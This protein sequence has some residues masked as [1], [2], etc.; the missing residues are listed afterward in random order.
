[1]LSPR[2]ARRRGIVPDVVLAWGRKPS[3][4]RAEAYA[5]ANGLPLWR[6]EDGWIR[7]AAR[8]AHSPACYSLLVDPEGVYYD[9]GAPSALESF[10][11]R[12][13]AALR[14]DVDERALERAA[15]A[16]LRLVGADITKYNYCRRAV[17][18]PEDGRAL[19]L[20]V[21]QT[22]D[23]ASVRFGG[24]DEARFAAML[25]A[26]IAENPDARVL[27]RTHPDVVA[28]RRRGYLDAVARER[29]VALAAAG[30][31]PL[32][33]LKRAARVYVGTSQ[34]GYEALLC[35]CAVTVFGE[36]FYAGWGLTDDRRVIPRRAHR[37]SLDELFHAAHIHLARYVSPIS[38]ERWEIED[39]LE[40]VALQRETLARNARHFLCFGIRPWKRRYL[41]QFLRSPDGSVRFADTPGTGQADTLLAWGFR[42]E[43]ETVARSGL[44]LWRVEDG[45][46]RSA[47]LG[48]NFVAPGSFVVDTRGLYFDPTGPSDL[49]VML[50]SR[51]CTL[52]EVRRAASLRR[53]I[54]DAGL[55]KYNIGTAGTNSPAPADR[56]KVL[57]VG[58]V[59]DDESIRRGCDG[60][61]SDTAL[62]QAVRKARP[63]AWIVY[64]PHPDVL[65]GNRSGMA[66][67]LAVQSCADRVDTEST[68]G[69]C[70]DACDELHT[71][72]SLAGFEALMRGR[73]V[74]TW[75]APFYA[76]W[77]LTED[78]LTVPRRTRR[79]TLDELVFLTLVAYP[80]YVDIASGEFV[81]AE[82]MVRIIEGQ[83]SRAAS[84]AARRT[85]WI[86]RRLQ[87]T[88]NIVRGLRYAP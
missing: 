59:G 7:S 84:A 17:L 55:S 57:V 64:R 79:R 87:R 47:G 70:I 44:P 85:G 76:G 19:V 73:N 29:G 61:D 20:V 37:R 35:G 68:I 11:N 81:T 52:A 23:D 36:P 75:G 56:G 72:T 6:L 15:R 30:D 33:W 66:D 2:A 18:P 42:E 31:D 49:E 27:V 82:D 28:G 69:D 53:A 63:D 22:R 8:D 80:R 74:T 34:L 50:E 86:A 54:L 25:D 71:M 67:P 88:T 38:G 1:M 9:S 3:A 46:L 58:Q 5:R 24:M 65:S 60:V 40:H 43:R 26:A 39:C 48:S 77:G 4:S 83:K 13:Q 62:L 45:F 12:P 78:R 32:P 41:A 16:R 21:D 51:D 10:L 14:A